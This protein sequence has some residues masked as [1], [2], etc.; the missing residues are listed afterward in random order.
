MEQ[1]KASLYFDSMWI[2]VTQNQTLFYSHT[3]IVH[4]DRTADGCTQSQVGTVS[5]LFSE[6][7]FIMVVV[8]AV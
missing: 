3:F 2:P 1:H 4:M 8:V 7:K 5:R 6:M